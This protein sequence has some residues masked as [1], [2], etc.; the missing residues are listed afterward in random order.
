MAKPSPPPPPP[1]QLEIIFDR[2]S[3][4]YEPGEEVTGQIKICNLN[5]GTY[6]HGE[7]TLNAEALMDTVS[8]IRG[9][10]GRPALPQDQKI[11]FMKQKIDVSTGG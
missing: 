5:G 9:S 10:V 2:A 4:F 1:K 7:V 11:Y 3:M 6:D 8:A